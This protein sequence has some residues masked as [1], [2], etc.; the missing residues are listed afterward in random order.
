MHKSRCSLILIVALVGIFFIS[1]SNLNAEPTTANSN[2]LLMND[3]SEDLRNK[4]VSFWKEK[5]DPETFKV[6]RESGTEA[7]F[8]GKYYNYKEPGK[9]YCSNCGEPLFSSDTKFDSGSGWPSFWDVLDTSAVELIEDRSHGMVRTEVRCKKCGAHL[10]HLFNDGPN[11]T[12]NRYC[13]NSVSLVHDND[14]PKK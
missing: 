3:N 12:G 11:P 9:Y 7:P 13:I 8:S 14:M 6:C 5:L 2:D 4:D 10:G 1:R